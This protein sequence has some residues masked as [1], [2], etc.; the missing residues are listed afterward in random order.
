VLAALGL[1]L[2][3]LLLLRVHR[4]DEESR[5]RARFGSW[6]ID[7]ADRPERPTESVVRVDSFESLVRLAER[8]DRMILDEGGRYAVEDGGRA[9]V[10]DLVPELV[11]AASGAD[12]G[13]YGWAADEPLPVD[14]WR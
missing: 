14:G 11:S 5:I 6:L 10:Y 7:V 1:A 12:V 3:G 13:D 4:A 9:F 2:A 8:Y